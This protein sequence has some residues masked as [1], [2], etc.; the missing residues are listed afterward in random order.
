MSLNLLSIITQVVKPCLPGLTADFWS[1]SVFVLFSCRVPRVGQ[2]LTTRSRYSVC[3]L[4]LEM[5]YNV[6]PYQEQLL[7]MRTIPYHSWLCH[8]TI[9]TNWVYHALKLKSLSQMMRCWLKDQYCD[10][11]TLTFWYGM[12]HLARWVSSSHSYE[13]V[14][15]LTVPHSAALLAGFPQTIVSSALAATLHWKKEKLVA[16]S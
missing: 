14:N 4:W 11:K 6:V 9:M 5:R 10:A 1:F 7:G 12:T 15:I 16:W 3:G 8:S 2:S 13:L